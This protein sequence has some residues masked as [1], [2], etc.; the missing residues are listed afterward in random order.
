MNDTPPRGVVGLLTGQALAFGVT[1]ALLII[2]ANALFLDEYGSEW[3]PATYIAIAVVGSGASALIA[4]AARRTRLVRVATASLGALA[5][6]YAGSWVILVAGGVWVSALLLVLFP[7][8]LQVGFVFIGGQA[9]RLLDVRQ[10]KELFPRVVSGFAVGFL[11]GGLLGVPLLTLLGS[12]E[13]LLLAT[14][15]AQLAFLG[16]LVVTERR[17]PEVRAAPADDTPAVARPPLRTMFASG[18]ALLLLVYQVLSAM[19]S[20]VVDFLLFDRA[21]A[22]YSGDDLTQFLSVYTA[23]LNLV[24]ILFLALVAGPLMR[25]FGLRLGLLLNPVVVAGVLAVMVVVAAGPG[26]AAFG[27]F[28]LAGVLR[29][30]DIA[31]TD[32]TTRTSINAAYQIVPIEERLAVQ[33]VVEGIGVPVAIGATGVLLLALSVLDLG[34]GAVIAFGLVLGLIWTAIA[35]SVYRS[36]TRA[37]AEEMRRRS[38]VASGFDFAEDDAAAVRALLRSDDARDV[39]LGLDLLAGVTSPASDVELR[40]VAEHANPEVRV[41][42]LAQLAANGDTRA[43]ADVEALVDDLAHSGDAADR[44]AAAAACGSRGVVAID[45]GVLLSLLDDPDLSVRAAALDAVL[46]DDSTVPEVV[47]RVVAAVEEPRIAGSAT[48]ALRRLGDAAVPLLGAA[49]ARDGAP[50]RASLVRAAAAAA[51]EHGVGIIAPALRSS[52]RAVVLTALGALDAAGAAEVVPAAVLD[53]VFHDASSHAG[54][55]LAARAALAGHGDPLTRALEDE[56]DLARG[57]VIEVLALRHGERIREAVRVVDHGDGARRALGVEAL[58]V[59]ISREEAAVALPLVR[60]DRTGTQEPA[61]STRTPEEWIAD[62][63][64]DPEA[65]WRSPWLALCARHVAGP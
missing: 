55:A 10:M 5:A 15:V 40:H 47:R 36:Y 50:R 44:R 33:A 52:D 58:D 1:L 63:A 3:L 24:D 46:P 30:A 2:P 42:A 8:A 51:A 56:I 28:V 17:F 11:V 29:I 26:A 32:G 48:T 38:L 22:Q 65:V 34:T 25:R 59:A 19:G 61:P 18:L 39:R 4:R 37:L 41:R 20:Q 27:L 13:H 64:G 16:L 35:V 14:T 62:I 6:L 57:L 43:A 9:G 53:D 54:R 60:R 21:A 49:L 12:T 31:A 23:A 7:I 45:P